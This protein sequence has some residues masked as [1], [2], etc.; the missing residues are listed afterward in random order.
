MNNQTHT[1]EQSRQM[2]DNMR[3]I[4][5]DLL[6]EFMQE[7]KAYVVKLADFKK[8]CAMQYRTGHQDLQRAQAYYEEAGFTGKPAGPWSGGPYGFWQYDRLDRWCAK[9]PNVTLYKKDGRIMLDH[10]NV[11]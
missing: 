9:L 1:P 3:S 11:I 6:M 2:R 7:S 8:W 10:W 5:N 4:I